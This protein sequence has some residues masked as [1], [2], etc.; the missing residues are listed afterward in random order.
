MSTHT[1]GRVF[2]LLIAFLFSCAAGLK[3]QSSLHPLAGNE[4]RFTEN[5]GQVHDQNYESRSDV[6]F[7][8]QSRELFFYL[9]GNG[10]SYQLNRVDET[11]E[12]DDPKTGSKRKNITALS[13]YRVDVNWVNANENTNVVRSE[14]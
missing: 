13:I 14:R 12:V 2:T 1:H 7:C 10:I 5:K 6:L 11:Q 8:G 9:R 4:T 3:A